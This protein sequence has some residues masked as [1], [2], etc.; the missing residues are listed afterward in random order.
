MKDCLVSTDVSLGGCNSLCSLARADILEQESLL[1]SRL[2]HFLS[3]S[4]HAL[5]FPT[6]DLPE[7]PEYLPHE[8]KLLLPLRYGGAALGML[9][10]HG[11]RAR[12]V[13]PLL[14]L[15]SSLAQLCLELLQRVKLCCRDRVTGLATEDVLYGVMEAEAARVRAQLSRPCADEENVP[16]HRLCMGL[17]LVR[18]DNGRAVASES[19][20]CFSDSLMAQAAQAFARDVP[21]EACTARVGRFGFA[22]LLPAVSGR[23]V[24]R[25]LAEAALARL[26]GV[27]LRE[28]L[29]GRSMRPVVSVGYAIYPQDMTGG[30]FSLDMSEQAR[31]LMERARLAARV[32]SRRGGAGA[33]MSFARILQEGGSVVQVLPLGRVRISLGKRAKAREGQRFS[34]WEGGP[35]GRYKGEIVILQVTEQDSIAETLHLADAAVPLSEGDALSLLSEESG[36]QR[37]DR[38]D[39]GGAA[40]DAEDVRGICSHGMFLRRFALEREQDERFALTILRR[41][42]DGNEED[43]ALAPLIDAW[44]ATPALCGERVLAGQYGGNALIFYHPGAEAEELVPHLAAL[45]T[46]LAAQ[47]ITAAAGIAG[48]PFLQFRKTEAPECALK[49][50]E[51]AQLL[52][53]PHVGVCN[54]LALNISADKRYSLGDVFGAIEEYKLALLADQENVLAWNSLG[55]CYAALGRHNEAR[56][57]FTE[58]LQRAATV[59]QA[60]QTRYNLGT[61]CLQL[62]DRKAAAEYFRQCIADAPEHLYAHLRLG[63]LCEDAGRR[64]DAQKY[65]EQAAA[66]EEL[67]EQRDGEVSNVARRCLA[68][69]VARQRKGSEAREMLHDALLRNPH[70]DATM[71]MLAALY[72]EGGD[73]PAVAEA[74]A[75]RSLLHHECAEGWRLLSRALAAQGKAREADEAAARAAVL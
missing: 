67:R 26:S 5:Y 41:E 54:S 62:D 55:T 53:A 22:A 43:D 66:V 64:A 11:V 49:A 6:S 69:L 57:Y 61:V 46:A 25:Q 7:L 75:R 47:G 73:D 72:L 24:C 56:R 13:R 48:Y 71:R 19:G 33:V 14:P 3:F 42:P 17:V 70:D 31:R 37:Q 63:Q 2:R 27:C 10:L 4:G 51:Y 65:Y 39:D 45:C 21:S 30:E 50:L 28:P 23:G 38:T 40:G 29:S 34:V 32:A 58:A 52:P 44:K 59:E 16:L 9:M 68:R 60:V 18:V 12:E 8:R 20:F 1:I 36:A 35:R 15:L 74:L